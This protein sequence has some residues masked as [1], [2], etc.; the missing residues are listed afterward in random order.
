[1]LYGDS[2]EL[3]KMEQDCTDQ[4][5]DKHFTLLPHHWDD[6]RKRIHNAFPLC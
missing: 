3:Q 4:D 1:M 5:L 2:P 6:G